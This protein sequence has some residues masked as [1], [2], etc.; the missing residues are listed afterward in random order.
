MEYEWDP[1]KAQSN[2]VKHGIR[3][4]DA[5]GV[6]TDEYAVTVEDPDDEEQRYMT[7]GLDLLFRIV[8]VVYTWRNHTIRVISA[9]KATRNERKEYLKGL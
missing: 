6:F 8:V 3:F 4:A 1:E 5:V 7:L 9:R 2:F